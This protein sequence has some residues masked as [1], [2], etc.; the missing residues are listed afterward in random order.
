MARSII[1]CGFV[2]S[3]LV[4]PFYLLPTYW[5]HL[6]AALD[7]ILFPRVLQNHEIQWSPGVASRES[8][9]PNIIIILADDLGHTVSPSLLS[10]TLLPLL[11]LRL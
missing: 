8:N 5:V 2:V 7:W 1:R 10:L 11:S 3:L 4:L 9:K 6:P